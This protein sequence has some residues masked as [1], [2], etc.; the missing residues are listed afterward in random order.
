MCDVFC[1][2]LNLQVLWGDHDWSVPQGHQEGPEDQLDHQ[3]GHEASRTS[4]S[5]SCRKIVQR[6]NFYFTK[7]IFWTYLTILSSVGIHIT[8]SPKFLVKSHQI[9]DYLLYEGWLVQGSI[10][11]LSLITL[12]YNSACWIHLWCKLCQNLLIDPSLVYFL[13]FH[14]QFGD[15]PE[16]VVFKYYKGVFGS[17]PLK[18]FLKLWAMNEYW[19][20]LQ[21][22]SVLVRY[23]NDE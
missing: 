23:T 18:I 14:Y 10:I 20:S 9:V 22:D 5:Y 7:F 19:A 15:K 2:G 12:R 6:Y 16:H 1:S 8:D 13:P 21:T 11:F 3:A 17:E 4:G